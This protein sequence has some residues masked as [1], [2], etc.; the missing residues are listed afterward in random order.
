MR[1]VSAIVSRDIKRFLQHP[2]RLLGAVVRS[3]LWLLVVGGGIGS[4][5]TLK[6][7]IHYQ[8]YLY[9]GMLGLT[10]L[11]G[12]VLASMG[13]AL[14][15]E[16]GVMRALLVAPISRYVVVCSR[17]LSVMLIALLQVLILMVILWPLGFGVPSSHL[18]LLALTLTLSAWMC[19]SG[20]TL[21]A[22]LCNTA[23]SY[24][25]V[26]NFIVFPLFFLSGALY[27]LSHLPK[28]MLVLVQLNPFSYA[29]DALQQAAGLTSL[30]HHSFALDVLVLLVVAIAFTAASSLLFARLKAEKMITHY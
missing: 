13:V 17:I 26:L 10:L 25:V 7:N 27:P 5:L 22:V 11:F 29:I 2:V 9:P 16:S 30:S 3:M 15:R 18:G 14:D 21:I 20:G 12:S 1:A 28:T 8:D 6:D 24:S 4:V 19:T 23:E